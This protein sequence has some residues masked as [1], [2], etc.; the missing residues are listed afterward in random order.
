MIP[1]VA[2][3]IPAVGR[4]SGRAAGEDGGGTEDAAGE[5]RL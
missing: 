1:S 3:Q 2:L 5:P 4:C